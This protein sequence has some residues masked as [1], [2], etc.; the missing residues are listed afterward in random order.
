MRIILIGVVEFS[1]EMLKKM[2]QLDANIVG[3]LT[4]DESKL[5]SDFVDLA[6]LCFENNI[7]TCY[8]KNINDEIIIDWIKNKKP[9]II[10]CMGLSQIIR[11][12]IL[13]IPPM[14]V[15]G[16]HPSLLPFNKG[17]HPIIWAIALG[18]SKTG[19]TFFFMDEGADTGDILHQKEIGISKEDNSETLYKK[20]IETAK[21][22]IEDFLPKLNS[23]K[24]DRLPQNISEGN[25]WRKRSKKDGEIDF[26]LSSVRIDAL[27][28]AL[29]HPYPGAHVVFKGKDISIWKVEISNCL[30]IESNIESGKVLE[31]KSNRIKVKTGNGAIWLVEHEFTEIPLK[32]SYI[33]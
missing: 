5:N 33:L 18:L 3:V 14:G 25:N 8:F 27:V 29:Y 15:V 2:I 19:S 11:P 31:V 32:E 28:R 9:D 1:R 21:T 17:R 24:Y 13:D 22:Q 30:S 12:E 20:V 23:E 10:F 16:F 26:R 7:D 6:P 4:K